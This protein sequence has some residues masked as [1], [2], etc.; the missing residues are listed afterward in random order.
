[1]NS[2]KEKE[3]FTFQ[4][5]L[6]LEMIRQKID[7][8]EGNTISNPRNLA[9]DL[10]YDVST[11]NDHFRKLTDNNCLYGLPLWTESKRKLLNGSLVSTLIT[12]VH[13]ADSCQ[14]DLS[15]S[16]RDKIVK[17]SKKY[18]IEKSFGLATKYDQL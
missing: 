5:P 11:I 1:M 6:S 3:N 17:N 13:L 2:N 7:L 10:F 9:L 12:L 4:Y 15:K 14:I 18:P 8:I 16:V